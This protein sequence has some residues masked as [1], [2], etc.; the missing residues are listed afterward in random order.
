[1]SNGVFATAWCT[2]KEQERIVRSLVPD[3]TISLWGEATC[4][5]V[6]KDIVDQLTIQSI[7][8][9]AYFSVKPVDDNV[10]ATKERQ[11]ASML[12][13]QERQEE[14]DLIDPDQ[15]RYV[16][17]WLNRPLSE[18]IKTELKT[19]GFILVCR[20][21]EDG[22]MIRVTNQQNMNLLGTKWFVDHM[23]LFD[24][25]DKFYRQID[26]T[27]DYLHFTISVPYFVT[28]QDKTMGMDDLKYIRQQ[29]EQFHDEIK[30][31]DHKDTTLYI[32]FDCSIDRRTQLLDLIGL[33]P[34][35]ES[36]QAQPQYVLC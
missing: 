23:R 31:L 10:I 2:T 22:Y 20:I 3:C 27:I 12:A 18:A 7:G 32:Q 4:P 35:V 34:Q 28:Q 25:G 24:R 36:I 5:S 1:M 29:V 21:Q 11:P 14:A 17:I 13:V 8:V 6:T 26:P 19:N 15:P 9:K 30:I 33:M 16:F